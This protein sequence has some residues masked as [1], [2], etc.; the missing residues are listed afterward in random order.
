ARIAELAGRVQG[1]LVVEM[2]AGQMLEDVERV[3]QGKTPVRFHGRMG[4]IMPMVDE[5]LADVQKLAEEVRS[6][7]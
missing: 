1:I 6:K 2:S 7:E 3:V 5:I 4:G